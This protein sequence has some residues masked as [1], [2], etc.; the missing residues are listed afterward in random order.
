LLG[1]LIMVRPDL[2]FGT[3]SDY[4]APLPFLGVLSALLGALGS[5]TAYVLVRRLSESEDSSVI[6][7]YFP[8]IALPVSCLLLW[9]G[10]V[11]PTG[12]SWQLLL[13][14]GVFTQVAQYGMTKAMQTE[15]AG[16]ASAYAYVQVIFSALLG[17]LCFNEIPTVGTIL[18]AAFIVSG[19]LINVWYPGSAKKH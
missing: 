6:I 1:L 15:H 10:F 12:I 17:W 4:E 5:G 18:G 3:F 19:A 13:L 11:L 8:F 16:K 14:V 7:F 9:D 2:L